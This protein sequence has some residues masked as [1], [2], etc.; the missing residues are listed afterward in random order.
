MPNLQDVPSPNWSTY[1]MPSRS[2]DSARTAESSTGGKL[3]RGAPASCNLPMS[4]RRL[5]GNLGEGRPSNRLQKDSSNAVIPS[6]P[7]EPTPFAASRPDPFP[8]PATR[9]RQSSFRDHTSRE[10]RPSHTTPSAV[11]ASPSKRYENQALVLP[12]GA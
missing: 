4:N 5:I 2:L 9:R 6:R 10:Q 11:Q 3:N 8:P 7:A 1:S 12:M